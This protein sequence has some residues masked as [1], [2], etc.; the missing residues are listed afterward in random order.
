MTR[1]RKPR[2]KRL[3]VR[4]KGRSGA[5]PSDT[6]SRYR[7][8]V[9]S[10]GWQSNVRTIAVELVQL[11]TLASSAGGVINAVFD[12]TMTGLSGWTSF[13]AV[14]DEFRVLKALVEYVPANRYNRGAT[15]TLPGFVA[16]DRDSNSAI[17][18]AGTILAYESVRIF[19]LDDPWLMSQPGSRYVPPSFE[20]SSVNDATWL[21][22]NVPNP[23]VK[24]CIKTFFNGLTAS[25][26]YGTCLYRV[27]VQFRGK[28]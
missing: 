9:H 6:T 21:T 28:F 4:S 20:M 12:Q 23:T 14:W 10:P 1:H 7:G 5:G 18:A 2:N 3:A 8:S 22:T 24:P 19:G 17:T 25:T 27:L 26:T 15:T 16:V 11:V 13:S